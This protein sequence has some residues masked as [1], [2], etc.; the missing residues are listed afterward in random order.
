MKKSV[1]QDFFQRISDKDI[2]LLSVILKEDS[3]EIA[4]IIA[5][6]AEKN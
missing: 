1:T 6:Y 3:E 4:Y 5:G 2:E